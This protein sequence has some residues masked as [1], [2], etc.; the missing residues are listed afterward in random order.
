MA[1]K[2]VLLI[3]FLLIT[4]QDCGQDTDVK[5]VFDGG[6]GGGERCLWFA[7]KRVLV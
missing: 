2:M 1:E 5:A 7:R 6:R 4:P 3:A